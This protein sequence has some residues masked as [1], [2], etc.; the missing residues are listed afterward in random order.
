MA[1]NIAFASRLLLKLHS[2]PVGVGEGYHPA[3]SWHHFDQDVL[4]FAFSLERE[5]ADARCIAVWSRQRIH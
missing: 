3:K 5:D 4:S 2:R 1:V